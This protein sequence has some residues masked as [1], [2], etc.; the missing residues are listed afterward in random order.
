MDITVPLSHGLILKIAHRL[1]EQGNY[2]TSCLPKGFLLVSNSLGLAEEAVG[3]GFPVVKCGL[4]TLFP[5]SIELAFEQEGSTWSVQAVFRLNLVEKISRPGSG[6]ME[7]RMLYA[8][9]NFMAAVIRHFPVVRGLLTS[10]SSMLRKLFHWETIYTEA[11]FSTEVKVVTTIE[12][13][14]GRVSVEV[15]ASALPPEITEVVA[16][17][18]QGAHFFDRYRDTSG[19]RLEGK[20]IG[21]WDEVTADEAWFESSACRVAFRL[22][23]V[24]GARLFRGRELIGSRLAW[25]GFGYT[26]LPSIQKFRYELKIESLV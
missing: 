10:A 19:I 2:A 26:F 8:T 1:K 11:D 3:F 25:A 17:N 12:A 7:N 20:A 4:Q 13:E 21:C 16:M 18:E 9:K 15:D 23:Q 6:T 24:E 5:G 14:T 22:G